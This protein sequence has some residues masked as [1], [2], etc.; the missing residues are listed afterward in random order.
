MGN[1][2]ESITDN[3][4]YFRKKMG[5]SQEE[6]SSLCGY[7]STYLGKI[8]RGQR[9]P[10]LDTLI[11]IAR[12]LQI[13]VAS[14]FDSFYRRQDELKENWDPEKFSPYDATI[15]RFNYLAGKIDWAGKLKT[16]VHLPWFQSE[17][18]AAE[19]YRGKVLW[20]LPFLNFSPK[21]VEAIEEVIDLDKKE[22]KKHFNLKISG[23]HSPQETVDFVLFSP[24]DEEVKFELFYPRVVKAGEAR[25][26]EELHFELVD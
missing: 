5:L 11:Q 17:L 26:L 22:I 15:K 24:G 14:F 10:S 8:E 18:E 9:S 13:P 25:P 21:L 12:T 6:L 2:K 4:Q 19:T 23:Y 1:L 20:E 7:S 3:I 16:I